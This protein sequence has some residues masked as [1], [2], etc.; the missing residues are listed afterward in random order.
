MKVLSLIET[1]LEIIS[2]QDNSYMYLSPIPINKELE[3]LNSLV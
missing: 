2:I 3:K 1:I